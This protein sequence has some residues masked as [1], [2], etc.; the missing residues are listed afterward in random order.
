MFNHPWLAYGFRPF[1]LLG[2]LYA[3]AALLP[4]VGALMQQFTMP[5]ALPPLA[6]HGHE[7]LF[8]FVS[9]ALVGFLLTSVP[10]WANVA[11]LSGKPLAALVLL[12][13]TGR[14]LFWLS[15]MVPGWLVAIVNLAFPLALLIWATPA[16][17]SRA[18]RRHLSIG[19]TLTIY[20]FAQ[21]LFYVTWLWPGLTGAITPV[22]VLNSTV[23]LMLVLIA[24]TVTRIARVVVMAAREETG[25]SGPVRLTPAREHLAV[26]ALALFVVADFWAPG[27]VVTGWVAL[28]AAAAQADRLS[29]WPWGKAM[30][31][32]YLL[33]LTVAYI[34]MVVGLILLGITALT[35]SLP[36]YSGRHALSAGAAGTAIL[37]VFC[38]AGLRHTGRPL[39]LPA[40]LWLALL[41]LLMTVFLRTFVPVLWPEYYLLA[42]VMLP[43]VLWLLTYVVYVYSYGRFLLTARADGKPG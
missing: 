17:F 10:S 15:A 1:F 5:M 11:H 21:G 7:M 19:I 8:G 27:H 36:G 24:L 42:G 28:A 4:W 14:L 39:V 16:L 26:A 37:A 35:D 18:G 32:L 6:W 23:N 41:T 40:I 34:W 33:L 31:R 20:V 25:L 9:A 22:T 3:P 29:E 38:I 12:W 13:L 2:A 43:F 30:T